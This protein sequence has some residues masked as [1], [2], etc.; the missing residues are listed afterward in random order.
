MPI[1]PNSPTTST[2]SALC[3]ALSA[4]HAPRASANDSPTW[5]DVHSAPELSDIVETISVALAKQ[6]RYDEATNL[7]DAAKALCDLDEQIDEA[8]ATVNRLVDEIADLR[9][10][11]PRYERQ[12]QSHRYEPVEPVR[13]STATATKITRTSHEFVQRRQAL[14]GVLRFW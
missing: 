8:R 2:L 10:Q 14:F 13:L 6:G 9:A 4:L 11:V 12:P 7:R 5:R 1:D 3:H